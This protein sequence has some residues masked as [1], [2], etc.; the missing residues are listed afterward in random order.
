MDSEDILLSEISQA[1][2]D[3]HSQIPLTQALGVIRGHRLVVKGSPRLGRG[4]RG[5]AIKWVHN[6]KR[7]GDCMENLSVLNTMEQCTTKLS[8]WE[9]GRGT[10][11]RPL[12][13]GG[14]E[15]NPMYHQNK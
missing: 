10:R 12:A 8:Q 5:V 6:E 1:P 11:G 7:P 3:K 13:V 2:K 14:P 4:E 15:F 9:W